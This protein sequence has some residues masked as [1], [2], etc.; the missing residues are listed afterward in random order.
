[1]I[2]GHFLEVEHEYFFQILLEVDHEGK[3]FI[4]LEC[5]SKMSSFFYEY[6]IEIGI[7][8]LKF[9]K[10]ISCEQIGE[11]FLW[12]FFYFFQ[13]IVQT[14]FAFAYNLLQ[15]LNFSV[16][17]FFKHPCNI[18]FEL[19]YFLCYESRYLAQFCVNL[20]DGHV[21]FLVIFNFCF[22]PRACRMQT[23]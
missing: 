23:T 1:M 14:I 7:I 17:M 2:R 15:V 22:L 21:V 10:Q 12:I 11:L 19:F 4:I 8:E 6:F 5:A 3:N 13:L 16:D 20:E 9:I 18:L